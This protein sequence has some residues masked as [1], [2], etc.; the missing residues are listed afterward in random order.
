MKRKYIE[1]RLL[2]PFFFFLWKTE[3]K[4]KKESKTLKCGILLPSPT[5]LTT[6]LL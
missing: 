2:N 1:R 4:D 3:K 6:Q 5:K